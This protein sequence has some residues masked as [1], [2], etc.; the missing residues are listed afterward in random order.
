M[1]GVIE[2]WKS[3]RGFARP[4]VEL[5]APR[6]EMPPVPSA[7]LSLAQRVFFSS[8]AIRRRVLFV[9]PDTESRIAEFGERLATTIAM[10]TTVALADSRM[11][12]VASRPPKKAAVSVRNTSP[13]S[14]CQTADKLWNVP[15]QM[16]FELEK[17]LN[18][19]PDYPVPFDRMV[20]TSQLRDS[21]TPLFCTICDGAVLVLTAGRTRKDVALNAK[22]TLQQLNVELLGAVLTGRT[23]PIPESIYRRL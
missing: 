2:A 12:Q 15:F 4:T 10:K 3:T 22:R 11:D 21:L 17:P 19:Q 23:F 18:G 9:S 13:W 5:R 6:A 7:F 8:G 20:F 16:L 1:S 14:D